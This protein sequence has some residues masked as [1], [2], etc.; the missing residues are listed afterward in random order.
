M[1]SFF[2]F[3]NSIQCG[4]IG[5]VNFVSSHPRVSSHRKISSNAPLND[6]VF[7]R[8]RSS[9]RPMRESMQMLCTHDDYVAVAVFYDVRKE[10][11]TDNVMQQPMRE[12]IEACK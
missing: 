6:Q 5:F 9:T 2:Q 7:R 11:S 3:A 4:E 1:A 8:N 10:T 12:F